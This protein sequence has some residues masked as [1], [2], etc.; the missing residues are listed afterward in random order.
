[1][2]KLRMS[3]LSLGICLGFGVQLRARLRLR[4]LM[5]PH[6]YCDADAGQESEQSPVISGKLSS[7][8]RKSWR[9]V[10]HAVANLG[11]DGWVRNPSYN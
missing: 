2:K 3:R 5:D 9:D 6:E 1:M 8:G 10:G 4:A 11:Q 7:H